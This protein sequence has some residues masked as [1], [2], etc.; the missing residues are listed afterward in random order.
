MAE[1]MKLTV[2]RILAVAKMLAETRRGEIYPTIPKC[3]KAAQMDACIDTLRQQQCFLAI[4]TDLSSSES[5]KKTL[6]K[7]MTTIVVQG[8]KFQEGISKFFVC[9]DR[10]NF[11][12]RYRY[13]SGFTAAMSILV[14][15]IPPQ[16]YFVCTFAGSTI[17][18][19]A[20]PNAR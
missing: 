13:F 17:S 2:P 3:K 4:A 7:W 10:D 9:A 19:A 20:W 1:A 5:K 16:T 15:L 8:E 12:D 11:R 18:C 14:A 6:N